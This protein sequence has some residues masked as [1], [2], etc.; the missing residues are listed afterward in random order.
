VLAVGASASTLEEAARV[1]Y[2][3]VGR[4]RWEGEHHRLDIGARALSK[5]NAR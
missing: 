5:A 4:I 1:A 2:E 3:A